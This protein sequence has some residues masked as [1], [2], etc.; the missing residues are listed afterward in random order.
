M[1]AT[2]YHIAHDLDLQGHPDRDRILNARQTWETLRRIDKAWQPVWFNTTGRRTSRDLSD[3]RSVPY[4][5]DLF[6][7]GVEVAGGDGIV[8]WTNLD[9]CV[10]PETAVVIRQK[11][12]VAPC[13]RSARINVDDARQRRSWSDLASEGVAPGTDLFTFRP[14]WWLKHRDTFPDMFIACE[15]FD[16]ILRWLMEQDNP[17]A[18]ICPPLLYHQRHEAFWVQPENRLH[19]PAQRHNRRMASEW[20]D[21]RGWNNPFKSG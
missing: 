17:G 16:T 13:C 14:S 4:I 3:T 2:I 5:N 10:V 18:E 21:S 15:A 19:N 8:C 1:K 6:N 7:L 9:V 20:C 11:L 12:A